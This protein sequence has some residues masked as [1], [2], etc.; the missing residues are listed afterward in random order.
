MRKP[1]FG[2]HRVLTI[3]KAVI[4][5]DR[6]VKMCKTMTM[7]EGVVRERVSSCGCKPASQGVQPEVVPLTAGGGFARPGVRRAVW[8][9]PPA[10]AGTVAGRAAMLQGMRAGLERAMRTRSQ[11]TVRVDEQVHGQDSHS[12]CDDEGKSTAV[13]APPVPVTALGL[14]LV[15]VA[16]V[17]RDVHDNANDVAET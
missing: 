2:F 4:S 1:S 16:S 8:T 11:H 9:L 5:N 15:G 3:Y 17:G 7:A 13:E 6:V 10:V 14:A 12:L